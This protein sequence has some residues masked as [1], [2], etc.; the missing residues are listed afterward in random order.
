MRLRENDRTRNTSIHFCRLFFKVLV[1]NGPTEEIT[2]RWVVALCCRRKTKETNNPNVTNWD[3]I[4]IN[5]KQESPP[6]Q[7][8]VDM[9]LLVN[10]SFIEKIHKSMAKNNIFDYFQLNT[11]V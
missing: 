4:K 6:G 7:T 11:F 5:K 3:P 2:T 8:G 10:G 1:Q 9:K